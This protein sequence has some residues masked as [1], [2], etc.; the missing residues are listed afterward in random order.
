M[1]EDATEDMGSLELS[2]AGGGSDIALMSTTIPRANYAAAG[3]ASTA[4]D[5]VTVSVKTPVQGITYK[6]ALSMDDGTPSTYITLSGEEG[7]SVDVTCKA[8]FSSVIT[9]TCSETFEDQTLSTAV[10]TM[11]YFK[12]VTGITLNGTTLTSSGS[13]DLSQLVSG[14]KVFK[15]VLKTATLTFSETMGTGTTGSAG[16]YYGQYTFTYAVSSTTK[17]ITTKIEKN[18][19]GTFSVSLADLYVTMYWTATNGQGGQLAGVS[20]KDALLEKVKAGT[21]P[22]QFYVAFLT[23]V[24][25]FNVKLSSL[26]VGKGADGTSGSA[27]P[28]GKDN[29]YLLQNVSLSVPSSWIATAANVALDKNNIEF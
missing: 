19:N 2:D 21:A 4:L 12:R 18:G 24:K 11:N 3:I 22:D 29:I 26:T 15:N 25:Q 9:L 16:D 27:T 8:A 28:I 17:S 7:T 5:A 23:F 1:S 14:E 10:C 6:W 20:T 13:Y